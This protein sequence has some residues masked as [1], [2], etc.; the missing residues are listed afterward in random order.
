MQIHRASE[1]SCHCI[2]IIFN[3]VLN[4]LSWGSFRKRC[5]NYLSYLQFFLLLP[6]FLEYL[7]MQNLR[8]SGKSAGLTIN[9]YKLGLAHKTMHGQKFMIFFMYPTC[10]FC[11]QVCIL[12]IAYPYQIKIL[13]TAKRHLSL[14]GVDN[15]TAKLLIVS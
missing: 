7:L 10:L 8:P 13:G 2:D 12:D 11:C 1:V 4:N 5:Q 15:L 9:M 3:S 14:S 6:S